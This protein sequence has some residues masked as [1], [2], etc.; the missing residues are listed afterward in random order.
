MALSPAKGAYRAPVYPRGVLT[1]MHSD[2]EVIGAAPKLNAKPLTVAG[3]NKTGVNKTREASAKV[4]N[5]WRGKKWH[6]TW[7]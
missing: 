6:K 5:V 2:L 1:Q 4:L 7:T 3:E